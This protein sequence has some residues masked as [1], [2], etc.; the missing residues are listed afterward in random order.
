MS[1]LLSTGEFEPPCRETCSGLISYAI[2]GRDVEGY[3]PL[4]MDDDR[5]LLAEM[6]RQDRRREM[7]ARRWPARYVD[8]DWSQCRAEDV[9]KSWLDE[10]PTS[11]LLLHGP[12]GT[13]KTS[14]AGL[15]CRDLWWAEWSLFTHWQEMPQ[16][17]SWDADDDVK[18]LMRSAPILVVDDFGLSMLP[19]WSLAEFD[20]LVEHRYSSGRGFVVTTNLAP[21]TIREER[22]WHR[23]VDRW[24]ES[25]LAVAM[26]GESMRRGR[27]E[28]EAS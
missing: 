4:W 11:S 20:A 8:A 18:R 1:E 15:V 28:A 9:L 12:V 13:G 23:F 24:A 22:A 6:E 10:R 26:P 16:L 7:L 14:A 3:C 19:D 21:S 17:L 25:M 5:C 27:A 2:E